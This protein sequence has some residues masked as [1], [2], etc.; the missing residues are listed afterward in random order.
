M[1]QTVNVT[2]GGE[3]ISVVIDGGN[4]GAG[5][6]VG[7]QELNQAVGEAK[8]AADDAEASANQA[9]HA[10]AGVP[11]IATAAGTA[12]GAAAGTASGAAA[13]A[14]A[15]ASLYG[16]T[17][18]QAELKDIPSVV[19]SV[20]T[21]GLNAVGDGGAGIYHK[22]SSEPAHSG[23]FQSADGAWWELS[24]HDLAVS[25]AY[26]A[27]IGGIQAM[28]ARLGYARIGAGEI[29]VNA[30]VTLDAPLY[31]QDGAYFTINSG[32]TVTISATIISPKQW[33]FRG[34]GNVLIPL[35]DADSGED[36]RELQVIWFGAFTQVDSDQAPRI[37]KAINA[38]GNSREGVV[39]FDCGSYNIASA[40]TVGR[41][42]KLAS[43][44]G[45]RRTVFQV[46]SDGYP[47]FRTL[48]TAVMFKDIQFENHP[49]SLTRVY[50]FIQI[51]HDFCEIED[52]FHQSSKNAIVV[53][54]PN[55]K[56]R[57]IEGVY[58]G[59]S[60]GADSSQILV[61]AEGCEIDGVR[62]RFSSGDGPT[63][64]V[65]I[66]TGATANVTAFYIR[67]V[68]TRYGSTSVLIN[69]ENIVVARGQISDIR[70]RGS[71]GIDATVKIKT[72][73]TGSV[74]GVTISNISA[75]ALGTGLVKIE[76]AS[77]GSIRDIMFDNI[78]D[79]GTA[80]AAFDLAQTSG[81][82]KDIRIGSNV[83]TSRPNL[84]QTTGI[85]TGIKS[86]VKRRV[87]KTASFSVPASGA[88]DGIIYNVV[89][90]SAITA[91][92]PAEAIEPLEFE[93]A[94][95]GT[96]TT[97]LTAASGATVNGGASVALTASRLY[98]VAAV[99][100]VGGS[101]AQWVVTG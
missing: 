68:E 3:N 43:T 16:L 8:Q 80:G 11:A 46:V 9:A 14:E 96:G 81:E 93:I 63:A 6:S 59:S 15:A 26:G 89:S 28:I 88:E 75:A 36:V 24:T 77:S 78:H 67:N 45:T 19:G 57:N 13:G 35:P 44:A 34:D 37:Q 56:I 71:S 94:S 66:G 48:H 4:M 18:A 41:G 58:G 30:N 85:V 55:C 10:V 79:S 61:Q 20:Y 22:V 76:Q 31:F 87:G 62:S 84:I 86:A 52:I 49:V 54:G 25:A 70:Y 73:G 95:T 27:G 2:L 69:A 72:S 47:V 51:D 65:E 33:I 17:S 83:V 12:A 99:R 100:N 32:V 42:V 97:T 98:R 1:S 7:L 40:M 91:T 74:F 64:I 5:A 29:V 53:N 101:A 82:L 39:W 21:T 90:A 60:P 38:L 50:P 92:L 23:K